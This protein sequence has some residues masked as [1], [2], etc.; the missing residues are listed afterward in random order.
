M[1]RSVLR[2]REAAGPASSSSPPHVPPKRGALLL[3]LAP[4]R[5]LLASAARAPVQIH[6]EGHEG[7]L[8][9]VEAAPLYVAVV[10]TAASPEFLETARSALLAA[11]EAMPPAALFGLISVAEEVR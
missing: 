3:E 4:P 11:L 2:P 5:S 9:E 8:W 1:Q 7:E 10:D 6:E